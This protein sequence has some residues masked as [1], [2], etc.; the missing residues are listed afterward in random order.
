VALPQVP[1]RVTVPAPSGGDDTAAIQNAIN[2][3]SALPLDAQGFRGA[4]QL[5]AGRYRLAGR[6]AITSSGVVPVGG[7]ALTLGSAAGLAV[8]DQVVVER[9]TTQAW[10]DALGMTGLWS[11]N[12][13]LRSERTITA[14]SGNRI[15]VDVPLTTA[16]EKQ[17][18]QALVYKYGYPRINHVGIENLSSDGQERPPASAST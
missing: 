6:L 18:T 7:T 3:A 17:Y 4:V 16:L 1:T 14:I 15:T 11:P 13:S 9:P 2:Q 8:G 10:I 12:W 5:A